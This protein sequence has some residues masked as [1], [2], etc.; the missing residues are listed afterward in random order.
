MESVYANAM[1]IALADEGLHSD[2]EVKVVVYFRGQPVGVFK[3]DALVESL[4]ILEYKA[5]SRLAPDWEAQLL[6]HL[7]NSRVELGLLL[8]FG[9]RPLVRRRILTNDQKLLPS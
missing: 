4:V 8:F 1:A 2:R 5:G 3:A 6:N 9:R 7:R